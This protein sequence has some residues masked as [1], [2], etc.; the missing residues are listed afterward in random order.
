MPLDR[1]L[2]KLQ[3]VRPSEW[4]RRFS[5]G[6]ALDLVLRIQE[7]QLLLSND[8]DVEWEVGKLFEGVVLMDCPDRLANDVL[9]I[10]RLSNRPHCF[11]DVVLDSLGLR[12]IKVP[13]IELLEKP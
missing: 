1:G 11:L 3:K 5:S 10:E 8:D 12:E 6:V 13:A 7:G 2:E 4:P 9:R